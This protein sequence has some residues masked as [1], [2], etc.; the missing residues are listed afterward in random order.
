MARA[1]AFEEAKARDKLRV[2][3]AE[4]GHQVTPEQRAAALDWFER[5]LVKE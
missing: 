2:M 4:V 1:R 3:I 5:W